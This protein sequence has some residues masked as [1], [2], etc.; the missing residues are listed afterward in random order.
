MSKHFLA[1]VSDD[2]AGALAEAG[3]PGLSIFGHAIWPNSGHMISPNF[4]YLIWPNSGPMIWSNFGYVI[5]PL[6]GHKIWPNFGYVIW[7]TSRAYDF[8]EV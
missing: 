4:G 6:S 8:G 7:T 1:E 2:L 3:G 5:W